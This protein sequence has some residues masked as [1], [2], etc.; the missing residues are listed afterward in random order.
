MERDPGPGRGRIAL[1]RL[2]L[3]LSGVLGALAFPRPGWALLASGRAAEGLAICEAACASIQKH[4]PRPRA[5]VTARLAMLLAMQGERT[6]ALQLREQAWQL[7]REAGVTRM[8]SDVGWAL[9]LMDREL[10]TGAP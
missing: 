8:G 3:V 1:F 9:F 2:A 6:R 4:P 10:G 7:G 5:V